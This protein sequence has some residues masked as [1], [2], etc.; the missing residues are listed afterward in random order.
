MK[1]NKH[2]LLSLI[3]LF[4]STLS[5]GQ[6]STKTAYS[7]MF[8]NVENLFDCVDDSLKQDEEFLPLGDKRWNEHRLYR[9]VQGLSKTI[10]AI[11]EWQPPTLIA[12][13]EVENAEVLK[14]LIYQ[15]GLSALNYRYIH[16]ESPDR[17]GIDV[18]LLYRSAHFDT[19][20]TTTIVTSNTTE[21][22][23][24][25]DALYVK[26][27]IGHDTLH[28]V[29]NHWPSKRGGTVAS[30]YKRMTVSRIIAARL[31]SIRRAA[32]HSKLVVMGDFN[33]DLEAPSLQHL[34]KTAGLQ[35][36]LEAMRKTPKKA[37]GS[38]KYQGNWSYIDHILLDAE[39]LKNPTYEFSLHLAE[40]PFLLETDKQYSG[41][42]P[43]R[44]YAGPRYIGGISDHLPLLLKINK[45]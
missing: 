21:H 9:K 43:K 39:W 22:F 20:H 38:Y 3:T 17:R 19:L 12:L 8:Y 37:S 14:K 7:L 45:Q 44:S 10:L 26:G 34:M 16:F 13:C 28:I 15:T 23:F 11:N 4:F 29:V 25:R 41:Y 24:T 2:L 1:K 36:S 18:A 27:C 6:D 31:D 32:P 5:I 30:E 33:A 40:L 42:K 35:S